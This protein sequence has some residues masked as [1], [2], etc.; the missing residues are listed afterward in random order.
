MKQLSI[1]QNGL[2]LGRGST[3]NTSRLAAISVPSMRARAISA[4]FWWPPRVLVALEAGEEPLV[5]AD[6]GDH[7]IA[8]P[9]GEIAVDEPDDRHVLGQRRVPQQCVDASPQR[10]YRLELV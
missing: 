3:S 6:I 2:S 7:V 10:Q 4:S 9:L 8:H 1:A 5:H